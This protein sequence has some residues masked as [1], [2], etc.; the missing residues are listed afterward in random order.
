MMVAIAAFY[1]RARPPAALERSPDLW[2]TRAMAKQ[3]PARF[4]GFPRDAMQFWHELAA[5]MSR[6]WFVANKPRYEDHWVAPMTALFDEVARGLA[7]AYKPLRL[8]QPRVLRIYRD[9]RFSR[10]KTPYKTHIAAVV[11]LAGKPAA[12]AGNA[13]LYFEVGLDDEYAG[14]GS[15]QFDGPRLARWR[16]AVVGAPGTA[17]LP[18]IARLRK[19]GYD[20][21][22]HDDYKRIPRGFAAD[23]PRADLLK[24]RGLI[25]SFPEMPA[26]LLHKPAFARWLIKHASATA[27]LVI[28][29]HRHVG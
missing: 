11:R 28:W 20:V 10:D 26:G 17:L 29:L 18:L 19:A 6:D 27:P 13:A 24:Q 23:H 8:G 7:P 3:T 1:S 5:E 21:R 9:V 12:Q 22:G 25:C 16:K 2:Y 4:A 15:Y 14:V